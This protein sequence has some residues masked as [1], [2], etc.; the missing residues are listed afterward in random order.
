MFRLILVILSLLLVSCSSLPVVESVPLSNQNS[1]QNQFQVE[2]ENNIRYRILNNEDH[3][4]V[5]FIIDK[6]LTGMMILRQGLKI[7][8]DIENDKS[9]ETYLVYP[10]RNQE[11]ENFSEDRTQKRELGGFDKKLDLNSIQF[12][13]EMIWHQ[14]E[15]DQYIYL[16][17]NSEKFE[18]SIDIRENGDMYYRISIPFK[19]LLD[20][21]NKPENLSVGFSLEHPKFNSKMNE[22]PDVENAGNGRKKGGRCEARRPE[23]MKSQEINFW[24][25]VKLAKI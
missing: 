20:G 14:N 4:V 13:N 24:F 1:N 3:L 6:Q 15:A 7:Y 5:E 8:F 21:K 9:N 16:D 2:K 11:R 10:F 25:S 19:I 23:G 18:G 17:G 22:S 12:K